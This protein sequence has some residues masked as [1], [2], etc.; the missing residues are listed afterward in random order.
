MK[1]SKK[2]YKKSLDVVKCECGYCNQRHNVE[3]YGT[4]TRCGKTI[5][6]KAKYKYE[7]YCR[8]KLWRK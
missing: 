7:M 8:L 6:N 3:W 1:K 5:D 4:C 2:D